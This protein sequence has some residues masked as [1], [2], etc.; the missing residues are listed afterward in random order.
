MVDC[1]KFGLVEVIIPLA[2]VGVVLLVFMPTILFVLSPTVVE[3]V[4]IDE[5]YP[6]TTGF[7]NNNNGKFTTYAGGYYSVS[8]SEFGKIKKDHTYIISIRNG[9]CYD[10][11]KV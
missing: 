2:I 4:T 6:P 3:K 7:F 1:C 11:E 10:V 9:M 5:I 8:D